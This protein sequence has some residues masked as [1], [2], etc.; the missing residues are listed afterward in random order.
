[1]SRPKMNMYQ[2]L[3][4]TVIASNGETA[5]IQ[6][7]TREMDRIAEVGIAAHWIYKGSRNGVQDNGEPLDWLSEALDWQTDMTDPKEFMNYLRMDLYDDAIFVFTPLG[8][9]KE[10][11]QGASVLDFAFAIHTDIGLHCS[12][13][14]IHI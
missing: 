9:L 5:E 11:P 13:S 12:L 7:R 6:I 14:L 3:H 8:D 4:T 2:S 10:L 1:M